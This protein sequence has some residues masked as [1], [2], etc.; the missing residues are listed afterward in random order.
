MMNDERIDMTLLY[1]NITLPTLFLE[2]VETGVSL[3]ERQR[4]GDEDTR[5]T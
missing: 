2:R 5:G 1:K 3:R 4:E